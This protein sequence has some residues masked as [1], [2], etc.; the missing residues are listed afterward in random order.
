MNRIMMQALVLLLFGTAVLAARPRYFFNTGMTKPFS[1]TVFRNQWRS[2]FNLGA[3]IGFQL[4]PKFELEGEFLVHQMQLDDAAYLNNIT[5]SDDLYSAVTGGT[6]TILDFS[7]NMKYMVP[8]PSANQVTPYLLGVFGIADQITTKKDVTTQDLNFSEA[9][10][11][12]LAPMAGL[13][14]GFEIALSTN[15]SLVIEGGFH[16][17]FAKETTIYF[18][19]KFGIVLN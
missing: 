8:S 18:P 11:S 15:T 10:E 17:L 9:R 5:S 2:G 6:T 19:L 4:A 7:A 13:G 1:P 16:F 12:T 14:L 3:G